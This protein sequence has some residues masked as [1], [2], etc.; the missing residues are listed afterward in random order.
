[1]HTFDITLT[2]LHYTI[3]IFNKIVA[4]YDYVEGI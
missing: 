2:I 4:G 1:M 3:R